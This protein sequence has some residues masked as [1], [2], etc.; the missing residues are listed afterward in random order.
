MKKK[1]VD[2]F[3]NRWL[4]SKSEEYFFK[5]VNIPK[6]WKLRDNPPISDEDIVYVR[7]QKIKH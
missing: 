4:E 5:L 2:E 6:G 1:F 7:I 3:G